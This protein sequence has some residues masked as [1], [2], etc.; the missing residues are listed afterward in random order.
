MNRSKPRSRA[1]F[2]LIE[3]L[4]VMAIIAVL[5]A[6]LLP[7]VQASREAARR[8]QCVNNLL[9][10]G[11]AIQNYDAAHE[12]LPPGVVNPTGPVL[13]TPT[14]YHISWITQILPYIEQKNAFGKT[15]FNTGVYDASNAT[16]RRHVMN[17]FLCPSTMSAGIINKAA[18]S[19][20]AGCH[21]PV[22]A[23]IDAT[24]MGVLFLNSNIRYDDIS[25]GTAFTILVSEKTLDGSELGW[26]SGTRGTLRNTG[27]A[28]NMFS[29]A[30]AAAIGAAG[31]D[32]DED[33]TPGASK[34]AATVS[35]ESASFVGGFSSK[36]PGGA[37]VLFCDG[38]VR[39]MKSAM[40]NKVLRL[41]G[42]RADGE[43]V[44]GDQ[45]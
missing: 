39:F 25:D 32:E 13:N 41:L 36:H 4:V 11:V 5:I 10:I 19:S 18:H 44:G 16:V 24:N 22:E 33:E 6:L 35:A 7:A 23:P 42:N 26:M 9:Q 12:V 30:A 43:L 37:N 34:K 28:V 14:G 2:T 45:F 20:Y 31:D 15:N 8:S 38:S 3:L 1:G 27:H 40:S 21:H 29:A 17:S